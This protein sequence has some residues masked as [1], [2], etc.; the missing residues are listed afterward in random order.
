MAKL[1]SLSMHLFILAAVFA[2]SIGA[3]V[4]Q[5]QTLASTASFSGTVSD[6]SGARL[7]NASVTLTSAEKGITRVF[8][9][10]AEGNFS[11]PFYRREFI[12]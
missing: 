9:A 1:R 3:Q 8:K 11:L 7:A 5:G 4:A 2:L 10:D 12:R 6:P